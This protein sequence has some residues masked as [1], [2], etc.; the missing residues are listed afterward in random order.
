MN[1]ITLGLWEIGVLALI[2]G[3]IL[4]VTALMTK[5]LVEEPH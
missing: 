5:K 1:P 2:G 3:T 4:F